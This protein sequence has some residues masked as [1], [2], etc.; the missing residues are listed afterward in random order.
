MFSSILNQPARRLEREMHEMYTEMLSA[1]CAMT[2]REARKTVSEAIRMC[3]R[4]GKI[5]RTLNLPGNYGDLMLKAAAAGEPK[6]VRIVQKARRERATDEDIRWWWN[7]PDLSR[8]MMIWS[9]S[10]FRYAAFL[11]YL[12]EGLSAE[13]AAKRVHNLFPTY[14]DPDDTT[15][16]SG[17]DRPLPYELKDRVNVFKERMGALYIAAQVQRFSSYNA[18]VRW[19]IAQGWI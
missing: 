16:L 10:C 12:D 15:K 8:R 14:G 2:Q 4:Q 11:G 13:E 9:E 5:D 6:S 7:L 17:E 3:K 18:F 19:A 1:F